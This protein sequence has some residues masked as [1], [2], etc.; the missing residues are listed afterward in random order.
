[1]ARK[2]LTKTEIELLTDYIVDYTDDPRITFALLVLLDEIDHLSTTRPILIE[3]ICEYA[4]ARAYYRFMSVRVR[5]H[6]GDEPELTAELRRK[7]KWKGKL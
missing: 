7:L 4:R 2:Q 5:K 6:K 3:G 1:M